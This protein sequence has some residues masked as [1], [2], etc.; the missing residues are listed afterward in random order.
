MQLFQ[1][2]EVKWSQVSGIVVLLKIV[3]WVELVTVVLSKQ[4]ILWGSVGGLKQVATIISP[5]G[6][7]L[8]ITK[9]T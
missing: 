7:R 8:A 5:S 3:L 4:N 2:E 6:S 1:S 9:C